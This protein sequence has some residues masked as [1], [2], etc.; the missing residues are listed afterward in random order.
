[1][2]IIELG[3]I[4]SLTEFQQDVAEHVNHVIETRQPM[5]LASN[6][7]PNAVLLDVESYQE[8]LKAIDRAEAIESIRQGQEDIEQGRTRPAKEF[9]EEMQVRLKISPKQ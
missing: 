3:E 7:T 1:M 4:C 6:G 2:Q 5:F 8:M 9:F